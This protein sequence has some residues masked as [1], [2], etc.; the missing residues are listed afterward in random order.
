MLPL[1]PFLIRYFD[2]DAMRS[3]EKS[4]STNQT[5]GN[6]AGLLKSLNMFKVYALMFSAAARIIQHY[7]D[8][9]EGCFCHRAEWTQVASYRKRARDVRDSTGGTCARKG[10]N[11]SWWVAVGIQ[12]LIREIAHL[13]SVEFDE[14]IASLDEAARTAA[15]NLL[16]QFRAKLAEILAD[17]LEMW[18]HIP[19]QLMGCSIAHLVGRLKCQ[20]SFCGGASTS[21]THKRLHTAFQLDC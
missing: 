21:L 1:L 13:S 2:L 18:Y 10:R 19:W 15:I 4:Q 9:L 8:C 16:I 14:A 5:L 6:L 3:S 17:K 7:C 20:R 12:L 11:G